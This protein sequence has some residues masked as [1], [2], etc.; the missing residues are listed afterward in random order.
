MEPG[1]AMELLGKS[2][3]ELRDFCASLGEPGYR[4]SQIYHALYAEKKFSLAAVS[5]LPARLRGRLAQKTSVTL[6][7]IRQRYASQ[8]GSV[9]YLFSLPAGDSQSAARPASV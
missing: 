7:T 2:K 3:S 4:G 6:P 8:D 5:N 9:R 1:S